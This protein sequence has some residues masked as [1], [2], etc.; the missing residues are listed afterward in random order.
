MSAL[1]GLAEVDQLFV[2]Q[3]FAPLINKYDVSLV[4]PDGKGPGQPVCYVQ[5]KRMKI[6]EEINFFA[7]ET[8]K[9]PVLRLKKRN[10]ME[11]RGATDVLLPDGTVIGQLRKEFGKSLFR[12][13][14]Q[15]LDAQGN[16]VATA[17]ERS[18]FIAILRRVWGM[19]PVVEN[20]PFFIPF[21]FEINIDGNKVGDYTR[22][23]GIG[24]DRYL[25]DLRGDTERRIDRRVAV[26][27]TIALDALQDR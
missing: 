19:I 9:E 16:V 15:I 8:Q 14:W 18:M 13:S 20:I 22:P 5:Q 4:G 10:V 1:D 25:L 11:F 23:P 7:D 26:A 17:Q 12:S 2:K 24:T 27:F 6:R 21:H 3:R